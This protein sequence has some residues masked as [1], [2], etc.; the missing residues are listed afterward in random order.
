[1]DLKKELVVSDA[2]PLVQLAVSD[3]LYILPATFRVVIPEEVFE[4]TQYYDD[5]PDAIEI[6]KATR[7]WLTVKPVRNKTKLRLLT[8]RMRLGKGEAE[9]IILCNELKASAV[10]TSDHYAAIRAKEYGI[11]TINLADVIRQSYRSKVLTPAQVIDLTDRL[12][13]QSILDTR[14]IR[15]LREEAKGWP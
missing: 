1:M 2:S 9:A 12:I 7:T 10:L 5:L 6:A 3:Y 11:D 14:Y 8:T 15:D 13:N 4:E